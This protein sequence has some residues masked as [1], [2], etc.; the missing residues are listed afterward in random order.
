MKTANNAPVYAAIYA[1]LAE[2][3]RKHGYALAI[4]GSLSRDFDIIA[5]PWIELPNDPDVVIKEI[6]ETFDIRMIGESTE[7]LHGRKCYSI[8]IG[9]G[10]CQLDFSFMPRYL[11]L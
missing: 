1:E 7:K 9:F 10:E 4:H 5:I 8:F 6:T 2:I 11:K 3:T